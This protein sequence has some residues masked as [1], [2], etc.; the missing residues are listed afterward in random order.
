[1]PNNNS[2]R[3]LSGRKL[4]NVLFF[5]AINIAIV[6]YLAVKEFGSGARSA[7]NLAKLDVN[8]AYLI[9][10]FAC[11]GLAVWMETAKYRA[12][13]ISS[14]GRDDPRGAFECAV[15]G[16]YYDNITPL[17]AGGQPFQM[18]YLKKRGLSTGSSAALPIAG[19]LFLQFAFVFIAAFVFIFHGSVAQDIPAVRISAYVGLAFYLFVPLCI[20]LFAFIPRAFGKMVCAA[21][22]LL[23]WMHIVKDYDKAVGFI[24]GSLGEYTE[25]LKMLRTSPHLAGKLLLYSFIYQMSIMSIPF[26]VLRAFGGTNDWWTVFSLVVYIYSAITIIPTPGN[27][28]AAEGSFYAVFSSLTL[29]YLFWAMLVWRVIVYYFWLLLGLAVVTRSAVPSKKARQKRPI[30]DGPLHVALFTDLFY[31]SIDGV[32]RTVD[33]YAKRLNTGGGGCCVVCPCGGTP[34][35]DDK[36]PYEVIRT[37]AVKLPGLSYLIPA[38]LFSRSLK[39]WF[40]GRQFDVFHV[41]SPFLIGRFA[42][43]MGRKMGVPVVATF[44]SKFYDDALNI[45]HSR[46]CARVVANMVVNFFCSVDA[47]WAC[48]LGAANTLR[49]YG[50][51]GEITVMENGV[52]P[53]NVAEPDALR[54]RAVSEFNLPC[55]RRTLLFVGQQIWQKNL[56]LVLD[57]AK[58][59]KDAG[60][61]YFT[62][63]VGD[64]YDGEAIK[65]YAGSLS[66]DDSMLFTGK[67]SDRELL[68]GLYLAADL[69]FFPSVY[70]NAP[71]VLREASLM[72]VPSLLTAGSNSAEVVNDGVNGYTEENDADKMA[73]R[74]ETIFADR[75]AMHAVGQNARE[76]IPISWDDIVRRAESKYRTLEKR[77][78][79]QVDVRRELELGSEDL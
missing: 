39:K 45:T 6:A 47:V 40:A 78:Y 32:V 54:A 10:A 25:S 5:V 79:G 28:G 38:P 35:E 33:A 57:T 27:S 14:E 17:G 22:K 7:D 42:V 65:Q 50:F 2:T 9:F 46:F 72:S 52:E 15:L 51:K 64:G 3:K 20:I 4:Y 74:I 18:I 44:H 61:D 30:P 19:F 43:R 71:L 68:C 77:L 70:D 49:S 11:F 1:M 21:A 16:K 76:T 8:M 36:L 53:V 48:S 75:S 59:L 69:F 73:A 66:L 62:V 24:F 31:P 37:P 23:S 12:M 63:I 34:Y 56:R 67:I 29:G 26:F 13:M 58:R 55:G 41:H 60:G